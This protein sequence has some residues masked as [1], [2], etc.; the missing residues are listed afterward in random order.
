M[1]DDI[2]HARP[3]MPPFAEGYWRASIEDD[4][5][6]PWPVASRNWQARGEFVGQL[7]RVESVAERVSYRGFSLCRLCGARNGSIEFRHDKWCWPEGFAHYVESHDVRP[8]AGFEAFIAM[9]CASAEE[10]A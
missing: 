4:A 3:P 9:T 1:A 7:R 2:C 6:L 10:E 5:A 8:S